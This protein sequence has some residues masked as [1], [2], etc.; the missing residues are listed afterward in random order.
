MEIR[1]ALTA[2]KPKNCVNL[3]GSGHP[4]GEASYAIERHLFVEGCL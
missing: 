1:Y 3:R 4:P 2:G